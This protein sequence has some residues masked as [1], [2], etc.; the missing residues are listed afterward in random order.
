MTQDA[1]RTKESAGT[2]R[3]DGPWTVRKL[4]AWMVPYLEQREV[5]GARRSAEILISEVLGVERLKLYME[6]ERELAAGELSAL[7]ELVARAG[8]HEPIQF[9]VG[10]WPFLGRDF[11]VAPCTL[12]P[13][14]STE[15]LVEAALDWYRGREAGAVDA[16]D[17]CTGTGCIAISLAL[18]FR[19]IARPAGTGCR[20]I[21]AAVGA[22]APEREFQRGD[23]AAAPAGG[24]VATASDEAAG[25]EID[26]GGSIRVVATDIVSDAVALARSN[27]KRLGA[28]IDCRC[29]DLWSPVRHDER[30]DVIVSNP[31]YVT[32]AE[33]AELDRNVR[34]YEPAT[35]LKGGADGLDF[36]RR[37]VPEAAKR[38]RPGGLLLVEMGWK[39]GP[40]ARALLEQGP[41]TSVSVLHDCDGIDRVLKA[42]RT[43]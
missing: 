33:F 24:R 30:F 12:I 1:G 32:D 34:E 38:L 6:P 2:G 40:A 3:Q 39:H 42:E 13:R 4:L 9:L 18:G 16:L 23:D 5:D 17:L 26:G 41:W 14:P 37:I 29:G 10:K 11:Q 20:P 19:A 21:H 22:A 31:P 28:D 36:I 8:R 25:A 7:R 15:T 43:A 27:A 35:A